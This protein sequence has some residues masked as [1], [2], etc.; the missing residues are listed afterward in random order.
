M[1]FA[2]NSHSWRQLWTFT[3]L[4]SVWCPTTD[5]TQSSITAPAPPTWLSRSI[6]YPQKRYVRV[7]TRDTTKRYREGDAIALTLFPGQSLNVSELFAILPSS[8]RD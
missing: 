8:S 4:M 7:A 2:R 6:I 5:T 1:R 3:R